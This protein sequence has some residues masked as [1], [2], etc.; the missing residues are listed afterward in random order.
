MQIAGHMTLTSSA[1]LEKVRKSFRSRK[2][3]TL[4]ELA[5]LIRASPHTAR[6]RLKQWGALT[7][8]N[9]NGRYYALPEVVEFDHQG[10]WRYR[11]VRFSKQ[12]NLRQ[13]LVAL[14]GRSKAGLNAS[15]LGSLLGLDPRSFLSPFAH[16]PHIRREKIQGCF[17]YFSSQQTRF[18]EQRSQRLLMNRRARLPSDTE[19]VAILVEIIKHPRMGVE[20]LCRSLSKSRLQVEPELVR[21][22]LVNHG[23]KVK[24]TPPSP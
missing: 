8:Y 20:D 22:L 23:L 6:R 10:I 15:E 2:I 7:S 1:L 11:G 21:N 24:K 5:E 17:V 18:T 12:G 4:V 16:E 3:C 14:I 9:K 13:T 19:A